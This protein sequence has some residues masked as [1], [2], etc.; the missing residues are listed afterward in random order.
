MS[1]LDIGSAIRAYGL[2]WLEPKPSPFSNKA[3]LELLAALTLEERMAGISWA[4]QEKAKGFP[5]KAEA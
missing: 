2:L 4:M 3:R 1:A 5:E